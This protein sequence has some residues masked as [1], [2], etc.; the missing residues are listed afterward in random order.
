MS[1]GPGPGARRARAS[2]RAVARLSV[3]L[4]FVVLPAA[5]AAQDPPATR[6]EQPAT[7]ADEIAAARAAKQ[8]SM[9]PESVSTLE[10]RLNFVKDKKILERISQGIHGW[11]FV[12]GGLATGQGFAFG[13]QYARRDL[14]GGQLQVRASARGAFSTAYL[15]DLELNA[16]SLAGGGFVRALAVRRHYPRLDYYGPGPDSRKDRRS[17]YRLEDTAVEG[18]AGV[19]LPGRVRIGAALGG[20]F[21]NTGPGNGPSPRTDDLFTPAEAPGLD[22]QTDFLTARAFVDVDWRDNPAGPRAGGYYTIEASRFD[23]RGLDR[24]DFN[25]VV[26]E[27]Q[28]YLPFFNK[29]RVIA[30]RAKAVLSDPDEGAVVPFYL[31]PHLGGSESLRGLREYRFHDDNLLVLNAEYRWEAFTGLDMA[32][33][34]DAGRVAARRRYLDEGDLEFA[35]GFGFRFNVRNAT[36][37]R[38]DT[39]FGREGT[40]LWIKFNAPF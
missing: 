6:A 7:R 35:A 25:R 24:H 5:L 9:E 13:P 17:N 27:A 32:L 22:R 28:Q 36:F 37:L 26:V 18:T 19:R 34:A 1:I 31:Q 23:D 20:L 3:A 30:L 29:R 4:F 8:R 10:A 14:G 39:G 38:I 12:M 11:T 33:F 40:R 16:P 2:L 15:T 21:V